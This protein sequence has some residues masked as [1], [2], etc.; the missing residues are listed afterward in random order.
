MARDREGTGPLDFINR[1]PL[2]CLITAINLGI[3]TLAWIRGGSAGIGV[4]TEVLLKLGAS[5]RYF[6]QGGDYWRLLTAV[7]LHADWIHVLVNTV[8]MFSW[9]AMIERTVGPWWFAF[10]YLTTGVGS[11]AVSVLGSPGPSVGASGAGFG[12][13]AVVL[14]MLY[15]REGNWHNFISN[16]YVRSILSQVGFWILIG[17][18]VLRGMDNF[19]HVGGLVLGAG[20]GLILERRRGRHEGTWMISLGA[21]ILVWAGV[22]VASCIPGMGYG[23][24]GG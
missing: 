4:D 14:A 23:E 20:C 15:R 6:V 21:Y 10:A 17:F 3:F 18:F 8:F 24:L 16:P 12:M 1:T 11:F 5:M 2:S 9:C 13:I 7:F 22:V 19:A